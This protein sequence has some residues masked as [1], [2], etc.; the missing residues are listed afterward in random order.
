MELNPNIFESS[1]PNAPIFNP[2]NQG[3]QNTNLNTN[4]N[5]NPT[6]FSDPFDKLLNKN[7]QNVDTKSN[8]SY[9][10]NELENYRKSIEKLDIEQ[11][12]QERKKLVN[13][14]VR[15]MNEG[16]TEELDIAQK[17]Y[18]IAMEVTDSKINNFSNNLLAKETNSKQE[19]PSISKEDFL[20]KLQESE[21]L[22]PDSTP[23]NTIPI[24]TNEVMSKTEN[25]NNTST[26][27]IEVNPNN[28]NISYINQNSFV[29]TLSPSGMI[30]NT[31]NTLTPNL[32]AINN[33]NL[34]QN[35]PNT[36]NTPMLNNLV[37]TD[38]N[39]I[40]NLLNNPSMFN[41]FLN[42]ATTP[43][44][45]Y[46]PLMTMYGVYAP[47]LRA[48]PT[49]NAFLNGELYPQDM[50]DLGVWSALKKEYSDDE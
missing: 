15:L 9:N 10:N 14:I 27:V 41:S 25:I 30:N 13:E 45:P 6:N 48:N 36:I 3:S 22:K 40:N 32:N 11:L 42:F 7:N 33:S 20:K 44:H 12:R 1:N 21:I 46:S 4:L 38:S 23:A 2:S 49:M 18:K 29:Q 26:N 31:T 17:K 47:N 34:N 39:Q 50:A 28:P 43:V 24:Q 16:K 8:V 35:V 5:T 19:I 37:N